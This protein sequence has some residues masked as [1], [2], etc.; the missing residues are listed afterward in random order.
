LLELGVCHGQGFHLGRPAELPGDSLGAPVGG[1]GE[2]LP[3]PMRAWRQSIGLS[4]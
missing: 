3:S 2:A 4:A 1:M